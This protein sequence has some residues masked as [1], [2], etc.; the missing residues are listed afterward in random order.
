MIWGPVRVHSEPHPR[1]VSRTVPQVTVR[2]P[3]LS[4]QPTRSE[5]TSLGWE[6]RSSQGPWR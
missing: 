4:C 1:A 6:G 3:R 2:A 5:Q